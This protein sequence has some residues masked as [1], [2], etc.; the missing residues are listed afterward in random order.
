MIT[1]YGSTFINEKELKEA[2]INHKIKLEYYKIKNEVKTLKNGKISK[3]G[4][5]IVKTEYIKDKTK[6]EEKE[7]KYLS[8]DEER[9]N[10][11]LEILKNNKVTPIGVKDVITDLSRKI[12][13]S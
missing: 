13:F 5:N 3:F 4:I 11:I 6:V 1:L 9:V 8:S 10:N 12:I 7:I 2:E